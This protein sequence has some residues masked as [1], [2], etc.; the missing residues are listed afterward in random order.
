M[1]H[2]GFKEY[3]TCTTAKKIWMNTVGGVDNSNDKDYYRT[4]KQ[5]PTRP[6]T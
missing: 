6:I 4:S 5:I 2:C 1:Q 3:V